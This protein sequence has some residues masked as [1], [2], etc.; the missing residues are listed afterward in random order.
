[1]QQQLLEE[2]LQVSGAPL[3]VVLL[4]EAGQP[5]AEG[6]QGCAADLLAA[7]VQPFQQVC[8]DKA[9]TN[10]LEEQEGEKRLQVKDLLS[11]SYVGRS[12]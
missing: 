7:V 8:E 4:S 11:G 2:E 12:C 5:E 3:G 6:L 1:M 10:T 9:S